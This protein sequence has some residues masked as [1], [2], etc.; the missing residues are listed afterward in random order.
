[1]KKAAII[2]ASVLIFSATAW[3]EQMND[4]NAIIDANRD[5]QI[6]STQNLVKIEAFNEAAHTA[7]PVEGVERALNFIL[8][9]AR[10][11][12]FRTVLHE[13]EGVPNAR[14]PLYAYVEF[15]PED[16]PEM[17]MI[18]THLDT[19]P[20]GSLKS[21]TMGGP[22]EGRIVDRNGENHIVGRGAF[23]NKGPA[24]ASLYALRAIK[25][26]DIQLDRRIRLFFGTTWNYGGGQ[27]VAAYAAK[28]IAG[29][30][31]WPVFGFSPTSGSFRPAF[32]EKGCIVLIVGNNVDHNN[33]RVRLTHLY[34]GTAINV[35][36]DNSRATLEGSPGD[37]AEVRAAFVQAIA[38][39]GWDLTALPILISDGSDGRLTINVTG[40]AAHSGRAWAGI[41]ANNR[42]MYL[43][44]RAPFEED[45]QIIAEKITELL[46]P[47]E[48]ALNMGMALGIH[49]GSVEE[50]SS[51]TVNMGLIRLTENMYVHVNIRYAGSGADEL[52]GV[53]HRSGEEIKSIVD[54]KFEAAGLERVITGGGEP[55]TVPVDS[56][57]MTKLLRAYENATGVSVEPGIVYN[58]GY[59]AA[60]CEIEID[61][62]KFFGPRIVS[63]GIEGGVGMHGANE[64]MSV[65][66]LIEGTKIMA[67]AMVYLATEVID[68]A[69]PVAAPPAP[70]R[71]GGF[72][73]QAIFVLI[74]GTVVFIAMSKYRTL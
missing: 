72:P 53:S 41:G 71:A 42:M 65:E 55:Y 20:P 67:R 26:S 52:T 6:L 56:A 37:L 51:V 27:C 44:S 32:I 38:E 9:R 46:P 40:R 7:Y 54:A 2:A 23:A 19:V 66:R 34:G 3:G 61:T 50:N 43:L 73:W 28:A 30:E 45:W 18:L 14:G 39:R 15:G 29:E 21:W 12:G 47:D 8:D 57:V 74:L 48:D 13:W 1:M 68:V 49:E 22:F 24:I 64:S 25:D 11:M 17:I 59:A 60:W 63:W 10:E 5:E 58:G 70:A 33:A 69:D 35:V 16:A 4:V 36:S 62:E 31:E